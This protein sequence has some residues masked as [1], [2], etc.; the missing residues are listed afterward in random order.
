M[1]ADDLARILAGEPPIHAV[2]PEVFS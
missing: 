1:I 2:N